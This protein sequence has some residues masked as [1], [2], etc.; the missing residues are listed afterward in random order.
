MVCIYSVI[1]YI[2]NMCS[3]VIVYLYIRY[4]FIMYESLYHVICK[5]TLSKVGCFLLTQQIC[6]ST[7]VELP[8]KEEKSYVFYKITYTNTHKRKSMEFMLK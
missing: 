2:L 6:L 3:L 8:E 5:I 4:I 1:V 7:V